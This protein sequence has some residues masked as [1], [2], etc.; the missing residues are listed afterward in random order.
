MKEL[1]KVEFL[2]VL[3]AQGSI[4]PWASFK[5]SGKRLVEQQRDMNKNPLMVNRHKSQLASWDHFIY[6]AQAIGC[7]EKTQNLH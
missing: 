4:F 3:N 2:G 7:W 5:F 6:K 1:L